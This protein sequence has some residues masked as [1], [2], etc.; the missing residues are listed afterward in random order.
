MRNDKIVHWHATVRA[1]GCTMGF[2][3]HAAVAMRDRLDFGAN[4]VPHCAAEAASE[5]RWGCR[6]TIHVNAQ[7]AGQCR[8][9]PWPVALAQER[10][11]ART[12]RSMFDAV[13]SGAASLWNR[14]HGNAINFANRAR[15]RRSSLA[16]LPGR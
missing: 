3:T 12:N 7:R 2:S 11:R 15:I 4:F 10:R 16:L 9:L 5:E 8:I 14:A 1:E 13:W 6:D